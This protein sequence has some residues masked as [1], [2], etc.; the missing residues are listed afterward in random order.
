MRSYNRI[1]FLL[2][3]IASLPSQSHAQKIRIEILKHPPFTA[4]DS[5]IYLSSNF[6]NWSPAEENYKLIKDSRGIYYIDLPDTLSY[7]EY[8]FTQGSWALVEGTQDGRVRANRIYS[9][10]KEINPRLIQLE[11]EGWETQPSYVII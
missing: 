5:S 10:N 7:F 1:L 6:N 3:A 8:K 9:A 4:S 11:I 2:F